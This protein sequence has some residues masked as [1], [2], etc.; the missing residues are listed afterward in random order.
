MGDRVEGRT[1]RTL[2]RRVLHRVTAWLGA[3]ALVAVP[4]AAT[5]G[6][7]SFKLLSLPAGAGGS[8]AADINNAGQVVGYAGGPEFQRA[9]V[10]TAGTP[11]ILAPIGVNPEPYAFDA[12]SSINEAGQI[13]GRSSNGMG[14]IHA[15]LWTGQTPIDLGILDPD[16]PPA[17]P[18][19]QFSAASALN[20]TGQI[21]GISTRYSPPDRYAAIWNGPGTPTRLD[22]PGPGHPE[23]INDAGLIVGAAGEGFDDD[24]AIVWSGGGYTNLGPG[25]ARAVNNAGQIAGYRRFPSPELPLLMATI[26]SDTTVINL[27]PGYVNDINE[28]GQ[29]VGVSYGI[30]GA[31][32]ALWTGGSTAVDLNS[33]LDPTTQA[34]WRLDDARA[35]NDRGWI[36]GSAFS[37]SSHESRAY[38]LTPVPEPATWALLAAGLAIVGLASRPQRPRR[39]FAERARG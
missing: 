23:D 14:A 6:G 30:H 17:D 11:T 37:K 8:A 1:R 9:V 13:A 26:W 10:W 19:S 15:T 39:R 25:A 7:Y 2:S 12:A 20:N 33:L 3:A 34:R 31:T 27:G 4:V 38:L 32:A 21:V 36:V 16:D 18:R 22:G 29:V 28:A 35:I 5:A 24:L